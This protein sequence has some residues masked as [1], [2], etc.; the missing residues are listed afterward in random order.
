MAAILS[1]TG[2]ECITISWHIT[3]NIFM[4]TYERSRNGGRGRLCKADRYSIRRVIFLFNF[5]MIGIKLKL[6]EK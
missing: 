4:D 6:D 2:N 3:S 1:Q 5:I